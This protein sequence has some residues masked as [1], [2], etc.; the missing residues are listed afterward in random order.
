MHELLLRHFKREKQNLL[1]RFQRHIARNIERKARFTHGRAGA[2]DDEVRFIQAGNHTVQIGEAGGKAHILLPIR[3][4]QL[5]ESVIHLIDDYIAQAGWADRIFPLPDIVN[6]LFGSIQQQVRLRLFCC[7]RLDDFPGD[8]DERA[9]IEFFPHNAGICLHIHS[10]GHCLR[11]LE[12]VCFAARVVINIVFLQLV[13]HQQRVNL[14]AHRIDI[15]HNAEN[16]LMLRQ[17]EMFPLDQHQHLRHTGRVDQNGAQ[18]SLL[19]FKAERH[20]H[21]IEA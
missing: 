8:V 10:R 15:D 6:T 4:A 21:A 11:K 7:S 17:I 5:I 13:E 3:R 9:H 19:R 16:C 20:F 14:P 12:Q 1:F 18:H 2:H